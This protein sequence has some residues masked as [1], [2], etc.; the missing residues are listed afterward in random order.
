LNL[1]LRACTEPRIFKQSSISCCGVGD[2]NLNWEAKL[3]F[4]KNFGSDTRADLKRCILNAL[5]EVE[6]GKRDG[7]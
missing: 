7:A 6:Q 3:L 5:S 4:G 1:S 2:P